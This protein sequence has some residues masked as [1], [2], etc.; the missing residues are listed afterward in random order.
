MQDLDVA[1]LA[2]GADQVGFAD[3][4]FLQDRR[5]RLRPHTRAGCGGAAQAAGAREPPRTQ[6][7]GVHRARRHREDAPGPGLRAGV[8]PERLQDLLPEGH[9]A[10]G[11]AEAGRRFRQHFA[12]CLRAGEAIVPHSRRGGTVHVRQGVHGPL[13]RCRRQA[14]REGLRQHDDIDQQH[15][16]EQLGRVLRR[17]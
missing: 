7:P 9:R 10:A 12:H 17:R 8:L 16:H 3:F 11:Q 13:L 5:L 15:T 6:E 1:S 4:A 14:L 2:L